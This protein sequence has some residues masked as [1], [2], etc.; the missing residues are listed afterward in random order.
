[1][2]KL[3]KAANDYSDS[4]YS[5][6]EYPSEIRDIINDCK[7]AFKAGAKWQMNNMWI[8]INDKNKEMPNN[9]DMF[10]KMENGEVRRYNEDWEE[11]FMLDGIVTHWMPIPKL[12]K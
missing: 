11:E 3:E 6:A 7:S 12:V 2:D 10:I 4:Y 5:D 1:M 8:S 9:E